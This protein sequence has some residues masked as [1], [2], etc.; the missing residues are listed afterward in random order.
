MVQMRLLGL[1]GSPDRSASR[2]HRS[3]TFHRRTAQANPTRIRARIYLVAAAFPTTVR[4]SSVPTWP[5]PSPAGVVRDAAV[6]IRVDAHSVALARNA[7]LRGHDHRRGLQK[8]PQQTQ[9]DISHCLAARECLHRRVPCVLKIEVG[10]R[11]FGLRVHQL[12]VRARDD[13]ERRAI[14]R[15]RH[16]QI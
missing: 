14:L 9:T 8:Q 3:G 6:R 5:S 1:L 10:Q 15:A 13:G 7:G 12:E 2:R 16:V 4:D 11:R